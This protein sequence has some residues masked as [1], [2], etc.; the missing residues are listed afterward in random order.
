MSSPSPATA[1]TAADDPASRAGLS[2]DVLRRIGLLLR[3]AG[4]EVAGPLS[5]TLL[6]GGRSN[7]TFVL[8]D[9]TS[10]WVLR[11]PPVGHVLAT[12]HDMH[13]EYRVTAGLHGSSVPVPQPMFYVEDPALLGTPF[14]VMGFVEGRVLRTDA[15]LAALHE[16]DAASLGVA[17]LDLLAALHTLDY[18]AAGL[19][20][21]GRPE[22][23]LQRQVDRWQ[24]QLEQ[25]RSRTVAGLDEL[26]GALAREVPGSAD[27]ALVHGDFRL[28]NAI[29]DRLRSGRIVALLDWEMATLGD[30]LAD[31][32]L[33]WLYWDGWKGIPNPIAATPTDHAGFPSWLE[34]RGRYC[35]RTGADLASFDWYQAFAIF[36]FAVICEGIHLRHQQGATVGDGFDAVGAMVPELVERGLWHVDRYTGRLAH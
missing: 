18:A 4:A 11:R 9:G 14:Y 30:P 29:V 23:Y 12:A 15:D 25:S 2:S 36:K 21:L 35:E 27:V 28:D 32:A 6:S 3:D 33:F 13:R 7:L 26:A 24:R 20:D 5:A 34:L 10:K 22:G 8:T 17:F 16:A 31:L 19:G 1:K